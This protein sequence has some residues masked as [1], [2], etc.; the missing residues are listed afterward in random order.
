V[1]VLATIS[2]KVAHA[3]VSA[4]RGTAV[5][6][7][8]VG[9][10]VKDVERVQEAELWSFQHNNI[11]EEVRAQVQEGKLAIVLQGGAAPSTV[12]CHHG[13]DGAH[14]VHCAK[15]QEVVSKP[16]ES[17]LEPHVMVNRVQASSSVTFALVLAVLVTVS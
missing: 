10:H 12:S 15:D 8:E 5:G 4:A 13:E 7:G 1:E 16:G 14:A 17:R 2:Q 3:I 9:V 6:T 11:V